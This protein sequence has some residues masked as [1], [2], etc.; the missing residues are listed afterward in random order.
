MRSTPGL[1]RQRKNGRELP[2]WWI[3]YSYGGRQIR[4]S[5]E[6]TNKKAADALLGKIKAELFAGT[7][8]PEKRTVGLTIED[9]QAKWLARA[10]HKKSVRDDEIR[11]RRII[12]FFGAK[13]RV[14]EITSEL[15]IAFRDHLLEQVIS[16]RTKPAAKRRKKEAPRKMRDATVNRHLELLRS[17]LRYAEELGY[18]TRRPK[19]RL[20][21]ARNARADRICSD[22]ELEQL[23]SASTGDLRLAII[24]ARYSGMRLGEI[25]GLTW[26]RVNMKRGLVTLREKDTKTGEGRV[27][28]LAQPAIDAL[29]AWPR[30][31]GEPH[32]FPPRPEVARK[33][34]KKSAEKRLVPLKG[35]SLSPCFTRLVRKLGIEDLHFHDLRGT[36]LTELRRA[37]ADLKQIQAI[38]GHKTLAI[39]VERYQAISEDE[40]LEVSRKAERKP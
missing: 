25:V 24:L 14:Q 10:K 18:L 20:L 28:P 39:L 9:L 3:R 40:L 13:R 4:I 33:D 30:K 26:D 16:R 22:A 17:A 7:H 27:V 5:T 12:A 8:F 31:I 29:K 38:S 37:G 23:L 32:V 11:F 15:V 34:A 21:E 2:T 19:V 6:T 1:Y 36:R 35:T